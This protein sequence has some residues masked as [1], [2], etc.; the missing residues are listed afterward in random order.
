MALH[1]YFQNLVEQMKGQP[2]RSAGTPETARAM[3]AAGC[4]RLGPGPEMASQ[5]DLTLP[6]RSGAI[7]ARLFTPFEAEEALI[8]F[9]HGGGWVLGTAADYDAQVS[10][11]AEATRI[12]VLFV[13]YRLAPEHPFPAAAEDALDA[14]AAVLAQAVPGLPG[15]PVIVMGDSAGGNLTA[16]VCN[17]LPERGRVALQVLYYPVTDS[18]FTRASYRAYGTDHPLT[19]ADMRWFFDQYTP[20]PADRSDPQVAPIRHPRPGGP[21]V[22]ALIVTAECDVLRDEGLAYAEA[23]R[24][25]GCPVTWRDA[26]GMAHVFLRHSAQVPEAAAD[27]AKTASQ[28]RAAAGLPKVKAPPA[29]P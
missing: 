13:E 23:L 21:G 20:N 28:I 17:A 7:P 29:R 18:D 3:T 4:Q 12:P 8:V 1:P 26:P 15:G 24:A 25:A 10:A 27:L 19:E 5:R 9:Y 22:P 16:V 2:P 6:G 14:M 11:L